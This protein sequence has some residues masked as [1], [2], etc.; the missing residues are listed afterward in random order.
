MRDFILDAAGRV[1]Y[2]LLGAA[3]TMFLLLV[4]NPAQSATFRG[5]EA[6]C[7]HLAGLLAHVTAMRD[8]GVPKEL[9]ITQLDGMIAQSRGSD[10]P[11]Y[12]VRD[13]DDEAF[14]RAWVTKVYDGDMTA[15]QASALVYSECM[16]KPARYNSV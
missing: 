12:Y 14:V 5:D 13:D 7:S 4:A 8:D 16:R 6:S 1:L 2:M 15:E 3:L 11:G 9:F 10:D